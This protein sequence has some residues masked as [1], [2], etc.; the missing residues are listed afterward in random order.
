M[1]I[2]EKRNNVVVIRFPL[3]FENLIFFPLLKFRNSKRFSFFP[4]QRFNAS[5]GFAS[6]FDFFISEE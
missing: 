6:N 5:F 1:Q 2:H 3:N 4:S